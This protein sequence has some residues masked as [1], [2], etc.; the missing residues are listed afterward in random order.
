MHSL[1]YFAFLSISLVLAS[2][3]TNG[4]AP[5]IVQC[6]SDDSNL[7]FIRE[8]NSISD[9]EKEW[10]SNRQLKTN[11]ALIEFL[12]SANLSDFNAEEFITSDDYQGINLGLAFS[13]GGYRAML[14]SAGALMALDDRNSFDTPLGGILQSAN[15]ISGLSG[16]SWLLGSLAM[17]NF[18]TVEEVVFENPYDL[19]NLTESRQLVNQTNLWKIILPVIG[20]NLTTALSFMNFWSNNKQGIKYDLAAKMM[21]GFETSLTDAWS[22][23]LAHQLFPQDDNNY[24]SSATWSDI[25][26]STAFANHDMPF[27]FVTALGR[28]PGTVVFNLNSTVIEMNP[29]EFGSFDPSLNTFTDIKYLGTP[30]DNGKPV[31]ACVNGFD[32]AGFVVGTSSSLFN[33]FMNTL[34]CDDCNSLNF[35]VKIV[36][37]KLLTYLSVT[38]EDVALYK[39]NPF[40]NSEF[41][42]SEN[43]TTNDTLYLIDGGI[44]GESIPLS[45][46]MVKQRELDVVLA[47]D[48][49][50]DTSTSWP[51]GS[52]LISSYERQFAQQGSSSL[53]P[54][55]PD[56]NTFLQKG[57]TARPAFFGCDAKNLT[58]LMK[59]DVV[60]PLVVYFANRPYEYYSNVSTLSL[61]FTDEQKKGLIQNGFDVASRLNNTIDPNFKS[62]ISCAIIRRE[63]E[64]RGIEQLEQCKQC[65]EQYCWDGTYAEDKNPNYVNFTDSGLT[66]DTTVFYGGVNASVTST[67]S[68][69]SSGFLGLFKRD[70]QIAVISENSGDIVGFS[71]SLS[72]VVLLVL[73]FEFI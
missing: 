8:A 45:T 27:M 65:F 1:I 72:I 51:D 36:L 55:V 25:R 39:P 16:S 26:D 64:R 73:L 7:T 4:Y 70:Q 34:V 41:A 67:S 12:S 19:W 53:C 66:N 47:F 9:L 68:S 5:G 54:Y 11:E 48:Y 32:N 63:Q 3:P 58:D 28:R 17:Q 69:S 40:Y 71:T 6:P 38:T 46:L 42:S 57:F 49:N 56:S 62:C 18:T 43:I 13:G 10:I 50:T 44:G 35:I 21:A 20:N 52:A 31:N 61:T 15:Y 24:G 30:V 37:K 22:R 29:F 33:L 59:D 23:G 60:P 2:S 14:G